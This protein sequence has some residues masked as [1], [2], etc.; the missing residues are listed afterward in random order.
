MFPTKTKVSQRQQHQLWQL[1]A[2]SLPTCARVCDP[3]IT[4]APEHSYLGVLSFSAPT[5]DKNH[6]RN[7]QWHHTSG[8]AVTQS[9]KKHRPVHSL[10]FSS[11]TTPDALATTKKM[12]HRPIV[13]TWK[14]G[15]SPPYYNMCRTSMH[16][17][18]SGDLREGGGAI[19][20]AY[21][22]PAH[23]SIIQPSRAQPPKAITPLGIQNWY[24]VAQN[25]AL[26]RERA[27]QL[28]FD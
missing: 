20:Q 26:P 1:S 22:P 8:V 6:P 24:R 9:K 27:R 16:P 25:M 28:A 19:T 18:T 17:P 2:E 12:C 3:S 21:G 13:R 5:G 15:S 11:R 10:G 4:L 7:R 23:R 14:K